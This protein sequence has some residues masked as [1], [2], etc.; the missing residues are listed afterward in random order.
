MR[1]M[2]VG[3]MAELR[4]RHD[5]NPVLADASTLNVSSADKTFPATRAGL[6]LALDTRDHDN[7]QLGGCYGHAGCHLIAVAPGAEITIDDDGDADAIT[8]AQARDLMS[9]D[10]VLDP[11]EV[12]ALRESV[13]DGQNHRDFAP[14]RCMSLLTDEQLYE[15]NGHA[16]VKWECTDGD[17]AEGACPTDIVIDDG[18]QVADE[19]YERYGNTRW[20]YG[21][22]TLAERQAALDA[23][24]IEYETCELDTD[25]MILVRD[26]DVERAR[27]HMAA[28]VNEDAD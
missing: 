11:D 28:I 25:A 3:P 9:A 7:I 4:L 5:L 1:K 19:N 18:W 13:W 12:H 22:G 24:K 17:G 26:A 27:A 6:A 15:R 10:G 20:S 8:E 14:A 16:L 21:D 2:T 23:A